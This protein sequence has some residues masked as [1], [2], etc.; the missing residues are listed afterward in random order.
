V[1]SGASKAHV[2]VVTWAG[3]AIATDAAPAVRVTSDVCPLLKSM[4]SIGCTTVFSFAWERPWHH[5]DVLRLG[6]LTNYETTNGRQRLLRWEHNPTLP[7][8]GC[9]PLA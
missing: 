3:M 6:N 4:K 7:I 1:P 2:T 8:R 9:K 5:D